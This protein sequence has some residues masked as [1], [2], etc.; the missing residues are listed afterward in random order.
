MQSACNMQRI[1]Y[2]GWNGARVVIE[3]VLQG[4]KGSTVAMR[5]R[6][7]R[8]WT[9]DPLGN[10][11]ASY[12]SGQSLWENTAQKLHHRNDPKIYMLA[13]SNGRYVPQKKRGLQS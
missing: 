2:R 3:H 1:M 13:F 5:D 10:R 7:V 12:L 4:G 8:N 11:F 9:K 6:F